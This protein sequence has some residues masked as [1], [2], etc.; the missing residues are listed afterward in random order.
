MAEPCL[1]SA[2]VLSLPVEFAFQLRLAQQQHPAQLVYRDPAEKLPDLHQ[3]QAQVLERD[4]AVE[5]PQLLGRVRA[6]AGDRINLGRWQIAPS[7]RLT[8]DAAEPA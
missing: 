4:D 6:V 1:D 2:Q 8:N 5:L 7:T 3:S